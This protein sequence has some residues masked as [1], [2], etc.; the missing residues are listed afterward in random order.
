MD[1][2]F[3]YV[4]KA[5]ESKKSNTTQNSSTL[6]LEDPVGEEGQ[7]ARKETDGKEGTVDKKWTR[8]PDGDCTYA[9]PPSFEKRRKASGDTGLSLGRLNFSG[10][11]TTRD[12]KT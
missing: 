6:S 7:T 3:N 8:T 2:I 1:H 11:G 9:I 5:N 4:S 10:K 12:I